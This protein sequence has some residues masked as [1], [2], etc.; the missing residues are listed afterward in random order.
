MK[1]TADP[2][3]ALGMTKG[4]KALPWRA[5]AE[6]K[7]FFSTVGVPQAHD[8]FGR[9]DNLV[10]KSTVLRHSS[11]FATKLSSRPERTRIFCHD[12][13]GEAACAPFSKERRMKFAEPT[14]LNR[15]SAVA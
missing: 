4:R 7:T 12:T 3:A 15:K 13:L 2:S 8:S 5:V 6:E 9:D 11:I 14:K 1:R 10:L